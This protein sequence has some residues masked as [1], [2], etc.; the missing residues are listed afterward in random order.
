[1][2]FGRP[3]VYQLPQRG[4][5][6]AMCRYALHPVKTHYACLRC[7]NTEKRWPMPDRQPACWRCSGPMVDLGRDFAAPR[8]RNTVQWRKVALLAA[9]GITFDSCGCGDP[10]D[11]PRTLGD[12]KTRLRLR[13][14]DRKATR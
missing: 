2:Q 7:R 12:A 3:Q 10:G 5:M 1:M 11:R 4:I 14:A 6:T 13:R 8:R 9:A